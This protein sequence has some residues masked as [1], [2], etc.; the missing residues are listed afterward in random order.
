MKWVKL[1]RV[2]EPKGQYD[3][4]ISHAMLPVADYI[5][6]DIYRIYFSG[7]DKNNISRI[8]YLVVDIN[9]PQDILELS[10]DPVVDVGSLGCYD[11]N[12]VSPTCLVSVDDKKYLY[13]MGWMHGDMPTNLYWNHI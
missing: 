13:I 7:R 12:G 2:I 5:E 1:G 11:D 3:W 10:K 6:G 9:K 8:G 4:L